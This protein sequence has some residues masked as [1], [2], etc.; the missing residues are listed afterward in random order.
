M[1]K[2]IFLVFSILMLAISSAR[3]Q[4]ISIVANIWPPY[5]DTA[6][7]G[8][9]LAVMLVK[10][11]MKR[12][13][14][15][16]KGRLEKWERALEGSEIGAYEVVA[17]IWKT[18]ARE[19]KLVFSEPYLKNNV[20]FIAH[21]DSIIEYNNYSDLYGLLIGILKDYAYDEKFMNDP[22]ILKLEAN[23]LTQNLLAIQNGNIDLAVADKRLAL[24]ELKT[25][26]GNNRQHF[27]FL[28]KPLAS[29]Q[30]YIAAPKNNPDSKTIITNFNKALASMKKDGTYQKIL[31]EYTF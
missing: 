21:V 4:E 23:R 20:V 8:N 15:T 10:E 19:E 29:R 22:R 5:V 11:A 14:Y 7:P 12:A 31:D 2:R 13:G 26:M 27:R 24:Y 3:A 6:L 17:A 9:G 18:K 25:F 1:K 30:L 28:A 16:T